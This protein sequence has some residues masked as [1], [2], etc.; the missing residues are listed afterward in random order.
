MLS[1]NLYLFSKGHWGLPHFQCRR[2][3]CIYG[4][5]ALSMDIYAIDWFWCSDTTSFNW[6]HFKDTFLASLLLR[7]DSSWIQ[8]KPRGFQTLYESINTRLRRLAGNDDCQNNHIVLE[9]TFCWACDLL[10]MCKWYSDIYLCFHL[11]AEGDGPLWLISQSCRVESKWQSPLS[12]TL[13]GEVEKW[14]T[15]GPQERAAGWMVAKPHILRHRPWQEHVSIIEMTGCAI[16]L[17]LVIS[18]FITVLYAYD[19]YFIWLCVW[20][21]SFQEVLIMLIGK[22]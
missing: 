1:F 4:K 21:Q 5:P 18:T 2:D 16:Y 9:K 13:P 15:P 20:A 8:T 12:T 11:K 6:T 17:F 22:V 3:V 7:F 19:L 10:W 14:A